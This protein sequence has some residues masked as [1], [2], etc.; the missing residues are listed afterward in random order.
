MWD[1]FKRQ[2]PN[3][4][5]TVRV[6]AAPF[7]PLFYAWHWNPWKILIFAALV[8]LTD[9]VDG[10]LARR[11]NVASPFGVKYDAFADKV[12]CGGLFISVFIVYASW[13]NLYPLLM[14]AVPTACFLV[15]AVIMTIARWRGTV[16][17]ASWMAKVKTVVLMLF[18]FV[19]LADDPQHPML[20]F[21][22]GFWGVMLSCVLAAIALVEYFGIPVPAFITYLFPEMIEQR[23]N[24]KSEKKNFQKWR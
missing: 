16:D 6:V 20:I 12:F 3:T 4:A 19:A 22:L 18:L 21:F 9:Y 2:L 11:F 5:T 14:F 15:Y 24:A 8:A 1:S 17:H 13:K 7:I 10:K 23:I